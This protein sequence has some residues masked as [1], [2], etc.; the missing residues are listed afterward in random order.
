AE[1]HGGGADKPACYFTLPVWMPGLPVVC[2]TLLSFTELVG[3]RFVPSVCEPLALFP[4]ALPWFVCVVPLTLVPAAPPGLAELVGVP[5]VAEPRSPV[6]AKANPANNR[7][8]RIA[9]NF[10]GCPLARAITTP[11]LLRRST[12]MILAQSRYK[13]PSRSHLYL[14]FRTF[15]FFVACPRNF[16]NTARSFAGLILFY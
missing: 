8:R 6:W 4:Y 10:M 16:T 11:L 3:L 5:P 14:Y 9:L 13:H 12:P 15:Y 2:D 1:K 7:L